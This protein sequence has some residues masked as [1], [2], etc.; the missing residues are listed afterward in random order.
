MSEKKKGKPAHNKGKS[1]SEET[2]QKI[3][4]KR[5]QQCALKKLQ[6]QSGGN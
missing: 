4:E 1:H 6:L 3:R 2:K 5:R